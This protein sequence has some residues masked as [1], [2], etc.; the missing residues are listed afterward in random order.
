VWEPEPDESSAELVQEYILPGAIV[1]EMGLIGMGNERI[2]YVVS[3]DRNLAGTLACFGIHENS[4]Y[5][6]IISEEW[7]SQLIWFIPQLEPW[8]PTFV[9]FHSEPYG[10]TG[11]DWRLDMLEFMTFAQ[12]GFFKTHSITLGDVIDEKDENAILSAEDLKTVVTYRLIRGNEWRGLIRQTSRYPAL[13]Q[14][15]DGSAY[16]SAALVEWREVGIQE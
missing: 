13:R 14:N 5:V 15:E 3:Q 10:E 9:C 8:G 2:L 7:Y 6:P 11:G 16:G 4:K 1:H 12:G